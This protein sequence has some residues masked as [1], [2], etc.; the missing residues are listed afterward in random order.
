[1]ITVHGRTRQQFYDGTAD[2][3]AVR[4]VVEAVDIPVIV[5]GDI[6]SAQDA[7][8]ALDLSG[9]AAVM[10]GRAHYGA[11][12]AAGAITSG[13]AVD[14]K[15]PQGVALADHVRQHYDAMLGH[16]GTGRGLRHARKHIAWYAE[17]AG[18]APS[19]MG[20]LLRERDEAQVRAGLAEMFNEN[21]L[22]EAA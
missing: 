14:G 22:A 3:A 12:W 9:A 1:M 2:W 5:N 20:P 6:A 8:D 19:K 21:R 15:P 4:A 11:P 18:I 17:R 13:R 10:V 7:Q 16:Y